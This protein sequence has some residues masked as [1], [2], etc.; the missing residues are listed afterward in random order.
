MLAIINVAMADSCYSGWENKYFYK[1]WRPVTGIRESDPGTGPSGIGDGNIG[2]IG[3]TGWSPLGAPSSNSLTGI[4]FTPPFPSYPSGHGTFGGAL[5]QIL[6]RYFGTDDIPFSFVSD[7]FDGVTTDNS[8]QVRP[9]KMRSFINLSQAE[10]ENAQ[11]RIYLGIHWNFD[12]TE[13]IKLGRSVAN[14]IYDRIY[15]LPTC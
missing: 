10:E 7:E 14:Y 11:S 2:T 15:L 5:F 13:S 6:R 3:D 4:N 12:K 9:L 8:G 1:F